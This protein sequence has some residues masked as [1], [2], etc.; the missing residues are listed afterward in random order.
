MR[1]AMIYFLFV[2]LSYV[3]YKREKR[4]KRKESHT[5]LKVV[6]VLN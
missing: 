2:P 3:K 5:Y 1:S 6:S 4:W